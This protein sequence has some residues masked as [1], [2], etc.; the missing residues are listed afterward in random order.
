MPGEFSNKVAVITGGSR[1][2]GREIALKFA[3]SG[4]RTVIVSSSADN[5]ATAAK[6]IAAA[7]LAPLTI[8]ADLRTLEGCEQVFGNVRDRFNRCDILVCSAG[9]TRAGNFTELPDQAWIDGYALKFFGCVRLCRIVLAAAQNRAG[10]NH[11]YWG[12][13]GAL[14]GCRI[15][16]RRFRQCGDGEFFQS[17]LAIGQA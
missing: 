7:G 4:A 13:R 12:W 3:R 17:A 6:T 10:F 11:Q 5:L 9:A 2:I 16:D 8:A 15:F 1:G 14:A